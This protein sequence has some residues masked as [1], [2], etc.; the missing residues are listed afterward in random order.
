M[1]FLKKNNLKQSNIP[2][3]IQVRNPLDLLVAEYYGDTL[4]H[5]SPPGQEKIWSKMR[6]NNIIE[7]VESFC[8]RRALE[9]EKDF[10]EY[11]N[12]KSNIKVISYEE[13]VF[14]SD[15]Y[16]NKLFKF[17]ELFPN[18]NVHIDKMRDALKIKGGKLNKDGKLR[19][20]S[21][22]E[23]PFPGRSK[24][25]VKTKKYE[26]IITSL[27]EY[28]SLCKNSDFNYQILT[29]PFLARKISKTLMMTIYIFRFKIKPFLKILLRK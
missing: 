3:I 17:L 8:A 27:H 29:P 2:I 13:M 11:K 12:Y 25:I 19:M 26:K 24:W 28:N 14:D 9:L 15:T 6:I 1:K 20:N 10:S 22:L 21:N 7:G 5:S 23:W 16:I 4:I 18:H